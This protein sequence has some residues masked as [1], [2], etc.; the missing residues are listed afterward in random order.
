MKISI[1]P[2]SYFWERQKVFDFYKS[3]EETPVDI[4]YLGETVCSKRR[5]LS[6]DD[7]LVIAD[8][9][10]KSGKEVILSTL[11]LIEAASELS[12][13]NRI[14]LNERYTVEAND[15][16]TIH[17]L[18]A[19]HSFV[20]GPHIN[21]YNKATL[22]LFSEMGGCRWVIPVE[23][24]KE[25]ISTILQERTP[26]METEIFAFGNLPL[27]FSARCYTARAHNRPKDSCGFICV[28]YPDGLPMFTQEKEPFLILNGIQTQSVAKQNLI[29]LLDE[30]NELGIDIIR[31]MP[32]AEGTIEIIDLFHKVM[33]GE[34]QPT[35]ALEQMEIF[36]SFGKCNGYWFGDEGMVWIDKT[37]KQNKSFD[38]ILE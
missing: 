29:T 1:G 5:E 7:W 25:T 19:K 6:L 37:N 35:V 34:I 20:I 17:N 22:K 15:M 4:V 9:L 10:S 14:A 11:T 36:H 38:S 2:I 23:L 24:G 33:N 27:A 3:L 26:G 32:Q 12:Y 8:Q 21:T 16:A 13:Q 28:D 30:I 31:I 18:N